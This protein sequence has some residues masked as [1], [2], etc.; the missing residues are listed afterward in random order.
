MPNRSA[1]ARAESSRREAPATTATT[2]ASGIPLSSA[3]N[4]AAIPPVAGTP[5][6]TVSAMPVRPSVPVP[7]PSALFARSSPAVGGKVS[8]TPG[9]LRA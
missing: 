4:A 1:K 3:V 5:H 9:E 2:S 7:G 6:R 8:T